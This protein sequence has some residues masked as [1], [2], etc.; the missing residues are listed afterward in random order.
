MAMQFHKGAQKVVTQKVDK[1][2][3]KIVK[4]SV[5]SSAPDKGTTKTISRKQTVAKLKKAGGT[6]AAATDAFLALLGGG[7]D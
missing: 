1:S 6:Q 3:K 5:A 4:S 2:P 7:D